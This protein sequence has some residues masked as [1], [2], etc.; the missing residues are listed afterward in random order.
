MSNEFIPVYQFAENKKV[1][2]PT[3]YAWIQRGLI[4]K[5]DIK[6]IEKKVKR[7]SI[8]KNAQISYLT[9]SKKNAVK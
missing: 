7:I 5:E 3:V 1:K 2:I 8:N 4:S 9:K 6:I